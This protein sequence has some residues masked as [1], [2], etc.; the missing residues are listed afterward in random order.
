MILDGRK[1]A[2]AV[3]S[4]REAENKLLTNAF[5]EQLLR[6]PSYEA[7]CSLVRDKG[8][9]EKFL[10][11]HIKSA[12]EYLCETVPEKKEMDFLVVK[13]DF[14]NLKCI[15]KSLIT[16]NDASKNFMFP[17]I[18]EPKELKRLVE[19]KR[20][21]ELPM[22]IGPT[23]EKAYN[24]ITSTSDGRLTEILIDRDSL[25]AQINLSKGNPFSEQ[26]SDAAAS[27]ANI[28]IAARVVA[29][30]AGEEFYPYLFCRYCEIKAESIS[31]AVR[32]GSESLKEYILTT[33]YAHLAEYLANFAALE[34]AC[35][36]TINELISESSRVNLGF[37]PIASYY[38]NIEAETKNLRLILRAKHASLPENIIKERLREVYV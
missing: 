6:T 3:A 14:H 19:E 35:D 22:W 2:Y 18:T 12:W 10:E 16:G 17:C 1:Y 7:A 26:I 27:L 5:F 29:S 9:D 4:I 20:F 38:L 28:K 36:S 24:I 8:V 15:L 13:N 31:L 21:D 25:E 23:A 11:L 37:A 33:R 32:K 30:G 34:K